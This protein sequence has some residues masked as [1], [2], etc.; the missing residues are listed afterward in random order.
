MA[1]PPWFKE[2]LP[3]FLRRDGYREL[4]QQIEAEGDYDDDDYGPLQYVPGDPL[5][6]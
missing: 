5:A 1:R 6:R 4:A 3:Q 2:R